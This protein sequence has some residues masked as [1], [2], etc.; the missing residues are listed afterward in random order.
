MKKNQCPECKS[1]LG[2]DE[3]SC[4]CGWKK[5]SR[6]IKLTACCEAGCTQMIHG[7]R[8]NRC[9]EHL[10]EYMKMNPRKLTT[11]SAMNQCSMQGCINLAVRTST[12][13]ADSDTEWY[14]N[15]HSY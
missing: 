12:T 5:S 14:C 15:E 10:A 6:G 9:A 7:P 4:F 11:G 13:K 3:T 2:Q 1:T 8:F